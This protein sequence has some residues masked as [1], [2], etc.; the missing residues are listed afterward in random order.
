MPLR[1]NTKPIFAVLATMR[2][3]I[4]SVIVIPTPTAL[5]LIA[6]MTGL[7]Q[8]WI[9]KATWP[10]PSRWSSRVSVD[11]SPAERSAPAQKMRP[12]P[13][14]T[15]QRTRGSV[16]RRFSTRTRE[17]AISSVKAFWFAGRWRVIIIIGVGLGE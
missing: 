3:F 2:M 1:A 6:A 4:G 10:P 11:D 8:S 17:D 7:R 15:T 12:W 13:V 16:E 9:A 5:P 14:T